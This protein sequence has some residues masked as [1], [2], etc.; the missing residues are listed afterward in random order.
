MRIYCQRCKKEHRT[1]ARRLAPD[2]ILDIPE[3]H[4]LSEEGLNAAYLSRLCNEGI[5]TRHE[6]E[7]KLRDAED[8]IEF[9]KKETQVLRKKLH[10]IY[11]V[12]AKIHENIE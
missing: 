8:E 3:C 9:L 5:E 6:L 2:L 11:Q 10:S 7:K 1:I 4:P 12:L